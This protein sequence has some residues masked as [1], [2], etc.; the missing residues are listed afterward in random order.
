MFRQTLKNQYEK[1]LL[2]IDV[3]SHHLLSQ[4]TLEFID[5]NRAAKSLYDREFLQLLADVQYNTTNNNG[6]DWFLMKLGILSLKCYNIAQ[7]YSRSTDTAVCTGYQ[8]KICKCGLD[9]NVVY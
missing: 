9:E 5:N 7:I 4:K 1:L 3:Y 8:Q 6:I 2:G